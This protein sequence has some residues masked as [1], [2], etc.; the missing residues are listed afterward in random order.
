MVATR[1]KSII[2]SNTS[3]IINLCKVGL[4]R[5]IEELYSQVI[6]P[7]A[8][9][10]ELTTGNSSPTEQKSLQDCLDK[11]VLVV[12]SPKDRSLIRLLDQ[13]LDKGEAEAIALA[14]ENKADLILLD[15]NDARKIADVYR[16]SKT[17]FIG[18][19]IAAQKAGIIPSAI[20]AIDFAREKGFWIS[21]D[22][23]NEMRRKLS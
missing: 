13:Q 1:I 12:R 11:K 9:F 7:R 17:G 20:Q 18:M 21:N 10:E 4:L 19:L 6:I 8:V 14:I 16:L 2:V 5:I 22:L 3:P 15:E 23:Y